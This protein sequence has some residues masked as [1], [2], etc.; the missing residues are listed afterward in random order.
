MGV[1]MDALLFREIA[2]SKFLALNCFQIE[3][4]EEERIVLEPDSDYSKPL[5]FYG[6]YFLGYHTIDRYG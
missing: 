5:A 3:T 4:Q 1:N 6:D 2:Q